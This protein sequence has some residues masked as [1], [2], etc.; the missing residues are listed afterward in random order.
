[1]LLLRE[2]T[3]IMI[4]VGSRMTVVVIL[5]KSENNCK[6]SKDKNSRILP[7]L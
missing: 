3:A 7:Y 5:E 6:H 4:L 2:T 1:M